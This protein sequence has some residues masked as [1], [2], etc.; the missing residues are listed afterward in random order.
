MPKLKKI[1]IKYTQIKAD[2]EIIE[3]HINEF[4]NILFN[5]T[6]NQMHN[7]KNKKPK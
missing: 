3:Q 2:P 7:T 1:K 6:Y 4:F 5:E